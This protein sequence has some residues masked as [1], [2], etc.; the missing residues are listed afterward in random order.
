[1]PA[2]RLGDL[3]EPSR[4]FIS[5][6]FSDQESSASLLIETFSVGALLPKSKR[7]LLELRIAGSIK[8]PKH[9]L[10]LLYEHF[11]WLVHSPRRHTNCS[12]KL[13]L[14]GWPHSVSPNS[15]NILHRKGIVPPACCLIPGH[16]AKTMAACCSTR[17]WPE[18]YRCLH[19]LLLVEFFLWNFVE[20]WG[21]L[22]YFARQSLQSNLCSSNDRSAECRFQKI[23]PKY[24][25]IREFLKRNYCIKMFAL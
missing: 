25:E 4:R 21:A 9:N 20:L 12:N 19:G 7:L 6:L 8:S 1:M 23:F 13:L 17:R 14:W 16:G 24:P 22:W 15:L 5:N 10:V 2:H 11:E 18:L 3:S